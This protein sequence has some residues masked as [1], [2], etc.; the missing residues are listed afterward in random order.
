MFM[1]DENVAIIKQR[2]AA[3][4]TAAMSARFERGPGGA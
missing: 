4:I 2:V 3:A 1:G